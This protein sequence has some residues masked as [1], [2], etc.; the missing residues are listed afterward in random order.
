M[1][2]SIDIAQAFVPS[3]RWFLGGYDDITL[4]GVAGS[5]YAR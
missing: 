4:D 3:G 1:T 2:A 5:G